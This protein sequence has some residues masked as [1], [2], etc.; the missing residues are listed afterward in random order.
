MGGN[1]KHRATGLPDRVITEINCSSYR[2]G[3]RGQNNARSEWHLV[4]LSVSESLTA[5]REIENSI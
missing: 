4:S 5:D 1:C 3:L 2:R